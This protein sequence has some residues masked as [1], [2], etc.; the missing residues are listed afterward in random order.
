MVGSAS[1]TVNDTLCGAGAARLS[2][3][4]PDLA[5]AP[6]SDPPI[7]GVY[8]LPLHDALPIYFTRDGM[9]LGQ[10][11]ATVL[12]GGATLTVPFPTDQTSL[13]G[14]LPGLTAGQVGR[15]DV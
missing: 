15:A 7:R 9:L 12:T 2:P 14:P 6:V 8:T 5:A 10:A 1:I 4:R 3:N 11:R 13:S